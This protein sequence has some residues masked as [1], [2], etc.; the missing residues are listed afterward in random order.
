[1]KARGLSIAIVAAA[2][3][4]AGPASAF[5]TVFDFTVDRFEADGNVYGPLDGVSD[6]VSEFDTDMSGWLTPYGTSSVSGGRLHVQSPG[7]H[8]PGPDGSTLDLTEVTSF[9]YVYRG[10]GNFVATAVFD[11]VIPPEG[12]FYHFTLYTFGGPTYFNEIFGVDVHTFGGETRIEQHLVIL[13]LA[14]GIY[15]TV[16]TEGR[17][18]TAA[19]LTAQTRFRLTYDDATGTVRSSFSLDGGATFESP[20]SS[21]PIFTEGRTAGL[22]ILGADPHIGLSTTSSTSTSTTSTTAGSLAP[23]TTTLPLGTCE[24]TDCTEARDDRLAIRVGAAR[25]TVTWAWR[26]GPALPVAAL[27]DPTTPGGPAYALCIRD[28]DGT[29]VFRAEVAAG[30]TCASRPC[31][32][33]LGTRGFAY[34][35][36]RASEAPTALRVV[37]GGRAGSQTSVAIKGA[38][39]FPKLPPALPL[40]AQ[41]ESG[42]GACWTSTIDASHVAIHRTRPPSSGGY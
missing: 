6:I 14:H 29:L 13:D 40:T 31:W 41:L 36:A 35:N 30:G 16:T 2:L 7:T 4:L 34:K 33:A 37:A 23:T 27:G 20:F 3:L 22:F 11:S 39:I 32:R 5:H 12:H 19:D 25:Q 17:T 21:V 24:R 28:G 38:A 42:D 15:Q 18:I 26:H 9:P 10:S 8:F 1:M